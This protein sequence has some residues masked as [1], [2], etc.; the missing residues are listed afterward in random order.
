MLDEWDVPLHAII[1]SL[2]TFDVEGIY[3]NFLYCTYIEFILTKFIL[4]NH[5]YVKFYFIEKIWNKKVPQLIILIEFLGSLYWPP[6]VPFWNIVFENTWCKICN[7][8]K[9]GH[10][11]DHEHGPIPVDLE[12]YM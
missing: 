6:K 4:I 3:P 2:L 9:L 12:V 1:T 8:A 5:L 7:R 11:Q 10:E